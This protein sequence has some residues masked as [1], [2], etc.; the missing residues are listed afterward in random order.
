MT[1]SSASKTPLSGSLFGTILANALS[2]TRLA[3][4][5]AIRRIVQ[6]PEYYSPCCKSASPRI[7]HFHTDMSIGVTVRREKALDFG[8]CN[9]R[10]EV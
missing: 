8:G 9:S 2:V 7:L 4:S 1:T 6:P 5:A 10:P 3:N